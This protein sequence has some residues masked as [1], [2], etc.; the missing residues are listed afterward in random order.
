MLPPGLSF[1]S[2]MRTLRWL[3]I[4]FQ[5]AW[6][7]VVLPGHTRGVVTVPGSK[8]A[9]HACCADD[10]STSD[11]AA[12]PSERG[13]PTPSDRA[14]CAICYFAAG[15]TTPPPALLAPTPSG[16]AELL[17]LPAPESVLSRDFPPA[18]HGRAPPVC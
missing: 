17:S 18:Y 6:L 4:L 15:V 10:E 12:K 1:F 5:F 7:N 11:T 3:F 16:V 13:E 14:R 8:P 2:I 9:V